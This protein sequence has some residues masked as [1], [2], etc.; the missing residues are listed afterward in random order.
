[1]WDPNLL[2]LGI[3]GKISLEKEY[4][5]TVTQLSMYECLF[6]IKRQITKITNFMKL[7]CICGNI[8]MKLLHTFNVCYF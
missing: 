1:V 7:V 2:Q 8:A 3:K 6:K 4:K 5:V